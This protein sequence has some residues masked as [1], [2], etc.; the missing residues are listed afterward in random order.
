VAHAEFNAIHAAAANGIKT[1]GTTLVCP[2]AACE[3]CA[4]SIIQA[5]IKR[6]VTLKP[7]ST[8]HG[9]WDDSISLAMT[10]LAEAGVEVV[11]IQG[12][13]DCPFTIRRNGADVRF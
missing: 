4:K 1:A 8:A 6:L 2:W 9:H 3:E 12:S 11:F 7:T 10:M 13:L 5:G